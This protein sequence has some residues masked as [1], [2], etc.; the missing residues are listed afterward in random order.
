M[1]TRK[2]KL[3]SNSEISQVFKN[4]KT[5]KN[6][7]LFLRYQFNNS[8]NPKIAFSIGL[9]Y[10]KKAVIRNHAKRILRA[11]A[12]SLI[13]KIKPNCNLVFYLDKNFHKKLNFQETKK[14]MESCLF[15]ANLL[16]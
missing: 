2:N 5:V 6:S 4:G 16:K 3:K 13:D 15:K 10:S 1:P 9:K 11:S 14:A 12:D 7:F 8:N